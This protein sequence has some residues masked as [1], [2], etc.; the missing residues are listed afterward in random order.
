MFASAK[1]LSARRRISTTGSGWRHSH[2]MANSSAAMATAKKN[3]MKLLSNQSSVCPRSSTTSRQ[4][5]AMATEKIPHP[6]IFNL[7]PLRAASTSRVNSGGSDSS[8]LVRIS[9]TM[10]IG[11]LMKNTHRHVQWSV[12][13]PPKRGP[14]RACRQS[15]GYMGKRDVGDRRVQQFHESRQCDRDGDEPWIYGRFTC[16]KTEGRGCQCLAHGSLAVWMQKKP[17]GLINLCYSSGK[18]QSVSWPAREVI[19]D[20]GRANQARNR[21][22]SRAAVQS[23]GLPG[24]LALG[25]DGRH[26]PAEGRNLPPFF[27]QGI[28]G[29]R[30]LHVFLAKSRPRKAVPH[31]SS[32]AR[33]TPIG[34]S[35][36]NV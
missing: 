12:I 3:T 10:P 31:G 34:V 35:D 22:E 11:M 24:H 4:A 5:K 30:S 14:I 15:A 9:E 20:Q 6:S 13:Q 33:W 2:T 29:A 28:L 26:R 19:H 27:E 21:P 17:V 18:D 16:G 8:R 36:R 25:P 7:P 1:F 32:R 23:K